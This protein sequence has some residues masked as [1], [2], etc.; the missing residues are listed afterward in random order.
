MRGTSSL[1][2]RLAA[3][4]VVVSV[5][6]LIGA[7]ALLYIQYD[8]ADDRVREQTLLSQARLIEHFLNEE[9]GV[10]PPRAAENVNRSLKAAASRFAV[11]DDARRLIIGSEGVT[12][13]LFDADDPHQSD[14][15]VFRSP[16]GVEEAYGIT[17]PITVMGQRYW[18][19]VVSDDR[20]M[21]VDAL[22]DEFISEWAWIWGPFVLLLLVVNLLVVHV[23]L[24][25][26][27]A[28]AA[29]A[30]AIGPDTLSRRL[31]EGGMP[32]EILPFVQA[33]N[34]ALGRVEDGY[35][36]ERE[37]IADAA[38][39]LRTPLA[40]LK[41]HLEVVLDPRAAADLLPDVAAMERLVGQLLDSARLDGMRVGDGDVA[42]L[43]AI[44]VDVA[45]LLAPVAVERGRSI[46]VTGAGRPVL[47]RGISD[48]LFRALRNL[49]ENALAHTPEGSTVSIAVGEQGSL[50]VRDHGPG[51]PRELRE[52]V[53]HR[54]WR[55]NR[56]G[57]AGAGLGLAIVSRTIAAHGGRIDIQDAAGG[58]A[59]IVI[60]LPPP[61]ATARGQGG[62]VRPSG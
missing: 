29:S 26:L 10:L 27:R 59:V 54:F 41:T 58:G 57:A 50:A 38:H 35:R 2:G 55:G 60:T 18:I 1:V 20:E 62:E 6:A 3:A 32:R 45:T 30:A 22:M 11:F 49:A 24:R 43:A 25:P 33:V 61:T 21:Y 51:I 15:F 47:V 46:E 19:Q 13:P 56:S 23:A 14:Y 17:R 44:A 28:A 36:A 5:L 52:T 42:D 9:G 40:V 31:P 34:L 4:L 37:F 7:A 12:G 53:F 39:E 16:A 48:F 8:A